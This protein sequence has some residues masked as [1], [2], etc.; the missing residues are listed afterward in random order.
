MLGPDNRP[1]RGHQ[2]DLQIQDVPSDDPARARNRGPRI[3]RRVQ[4]GPSDQ[5]ALL[6]VLV[7][8]VPERDSPRERGPRIVR[9]VRDARPDQ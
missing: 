8:L 2:I 9:R 4:D 7:V 6:L 5:V 3:V 1:G